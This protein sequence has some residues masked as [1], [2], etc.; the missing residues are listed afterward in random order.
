MPSCDL[1]KMEGRERDMVFL[2]QKWREND[3]EHALS[4][5]ALLCENAA[6]ACDRSCC[7]A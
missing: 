1:L 5:E 3:R 6:E 7:A 4:G 2:E